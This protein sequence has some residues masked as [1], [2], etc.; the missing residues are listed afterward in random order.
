MTAEDANEKGREA[1]NSELYEQ[2]A[3][4]FRQAIAADP[5]WA[6]PHY[7]LGLTCKFMKAWAES[8]TA[9]LKALEL[10]PED[11]PTKWN[12][13]ISSVAVGDWK[14]AGL[15]FTAIGLELPK[16]GPPWDF[17][18]GLIP[19]RVNPDEY[20]EVVWCHRLDPVRAKIANVP[21][22]DCGRRFGDIVLNDGEPR[23]YRELNGR[24]VPVF[25]ELM[26]LEPSSFGTYQALVRIDGQPSLKGL[27]GL[28]EE[29]MMYAEDWTHGIRML[30]R[31]C[32]EGLPH[33][34][35]DTDLEQ[36]TDPDVVKLG[37]ASCEEENVEK[38]LGLWS[39]GQLLNLERVL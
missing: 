6:V 25:N 7:N 4:H 14:N 9:N 31:A 35:H 24:E 38:V 5:E 17:E 10:D 28:F 39:G 18:L 32:S 13:A 26:V 16:N 15:A 30:C 33:D 21:L 34:D 27:I 20:P 11:D 23:G 8:K 19:I 1:M 2:A 22:P 29:H 3:V 37:I 12:L 36:D